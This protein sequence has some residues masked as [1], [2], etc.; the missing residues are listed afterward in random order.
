MLPVVDNLKDKQPIAQFECTQ[1]TG[2]NFKIPYIVEEFKKQCSVKLT[3][4]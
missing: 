2:N 4:M 3:A 1:E